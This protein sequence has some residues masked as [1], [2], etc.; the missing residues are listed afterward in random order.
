L[1]RDRHKENPTEKGKGI[2]DPVSSTQTEDSGQHQARRAQC[3]L[4]DELPVTP[5]LQTSVK[6]NYI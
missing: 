6:R 5:T 4:R 1:K 3:W 2:S